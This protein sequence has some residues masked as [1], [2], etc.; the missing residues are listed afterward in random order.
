MLSRQVP[1]P[2]SQSPRFLLSHFHCRNTQ[3][4]PELSKVVL[5][6]KSLKTQPSKTFQMKDIFILQL[7][8]EKAIIKYRES[9]LNTFE[10]CGEAWYLR[11]P[12][13]KSFRKHWRVSTILQYSLSMYCISRNDIIEQIVLI[14]YKDKCFPNPEVTQQSSRSKDTEIGNSETIYN[15]KMLRSK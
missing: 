14:D 10:H 2:L 15:V 1:H 9:I 12:W 6:S 4:L 13:C 7:G 8:H 3:F 11:E 5:G